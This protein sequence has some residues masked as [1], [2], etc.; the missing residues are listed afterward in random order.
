LCRNIAAKKLKLLGGQSSSCHESGEEKLMAQS[1]SRIIDNVNEWVGKIIM[2]LF[3]PLMLLIV[4]DVF[5]RYV[6]NRPWFYLDINVQITGFIVIMGAGYGLLHG[7]HIGVD[8]L[9]QNWS[10]KRKALFNLILSP[11]FFIGVGA[12]LWKVIEA[13]IYSIAVSERSA[14]S[15]SAIPLYPYKTMMIAGVALLLLQGISRFLSDF[16][17]AISPTKG[18]R[19]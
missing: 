12:L 7:A 18:G 15:A 13:S 10:A 19:S 8:I 16:L 3:L 1:L 17:A 11:L 5:T 2:W 9:V 6:L 4:T 14:T